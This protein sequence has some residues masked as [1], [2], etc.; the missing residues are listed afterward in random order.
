M[1]Q[2]IDT[3]YPQFRLVYP[4]HMLT[5]IRKVTGLDNFIIQPNAIAPTP[6]ERYNITRLERSKTD[7]KVI[8]IVKYKYEEHK[9]GVFRF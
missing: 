4:R 3:P 5:S 8:K 1:L 6:E 7:Q 2:E 9:F